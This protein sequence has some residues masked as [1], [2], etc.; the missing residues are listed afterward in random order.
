MNVDCDISFVALEYYVQPNLLQF[1]HV[2]LVH[3]LIQRGCDVYLT[4]GYVI[5]IISLHPVPIF[6]C[7][8]ICSH[9]CSVHDGET[10]LHKAAASG[11]LATVRVCL[12]AGVIDMHI[13]FHICSLMPLLASAVIRCSRFE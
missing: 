11:S 6:C 4:N 2:D 9:C 8:C 7:F 1:G 12:D 3:E 10:I 5:L 13:I